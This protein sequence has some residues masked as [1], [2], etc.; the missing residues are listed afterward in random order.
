M[1]DILKLREWVSEFNEEA[2]LADGF[3]NAIIGVAD[4][5]G[6]PTLV[7]YDIQKCIEILMKRDGMSEPEAH[8]FFQFNVS[9]AW[10]GEHTPLFFTPYASDL[11][12]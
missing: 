10:L 6:Q 1:M 9:G 7:V 2:L 11:S 12:L 4:R 5:C 8:E 3:E